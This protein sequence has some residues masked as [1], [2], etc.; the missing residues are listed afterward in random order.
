MPDFPLPFIGRLALKGGNLAARPAFV[1]AS[2]FTPSHREMATRLAASLE[3]FGLP[4]AVY[5]VQSVHRSI[6][7]AGEDDPAYTK[8]NFISFVLDE[9][10]APVLYVDCD[11]VFRALPKRIH[12]LVAEAC[13]FAIYNW[14]ADEHTDA[15]K[16]CIIPNA[17]PPARSDRPRYFQFSHSVDWFCPDQLICSGAVQFF[18]GTTAA[19]DL[20]ATWHHVILIFASFYH[21]FAPQDSLR[22]LPPSSPEGRGA[23][24]PS[25]DF[26]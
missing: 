14:L 18:S 20:L 25:F 26:N 12:S 2:M 15:F 23:K 22:F 16:P 10:R 3:R 7:A 19:R 17:P 21:A 11:C 6:S 24:H 1:V 5:E 8:A 4:F 13:D 9:F